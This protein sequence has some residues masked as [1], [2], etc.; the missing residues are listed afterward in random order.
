LPLVFGQLGS[1]VASQTRLISLATA[2]TDVNGA[3][4]ESIAI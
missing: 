2:T 1:P 4:F 3:S